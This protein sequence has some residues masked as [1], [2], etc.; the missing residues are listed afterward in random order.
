M[1]A[2]ESKGRQAV[3]SQDSLEKANGAPPLAAL[4]PLGGCTGAA[5]PTILKADY[6]NTE[7]TYLRWPALPLAGPQ[8]CLQATAEH[9]GSQGLWHLRAPGTSVQPRD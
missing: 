5:L 2:P 8:Q 4:N 1:G 9:G 7:E 6:R 3:P